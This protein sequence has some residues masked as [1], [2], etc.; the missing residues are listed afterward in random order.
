VASNEAWVRMVIPIVGERNSLYA[1]QNNKVG[2]KI[3]TPWARL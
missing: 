2:A 1:C 3:G